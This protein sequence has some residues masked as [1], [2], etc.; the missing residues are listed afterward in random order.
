MLGGFGLH[1]KTI[2]L[3]DAGGGLVENSLQY[4][5]I[6]GGRLGNSLDMVQSLSDGL[7]LRTGIVNCFDQVTDCR[8]MVGC[9]TGDRVKSLGVDH[10][11][12]PASN[13]L[14]K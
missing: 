14:D 12:S 9:V 1:A 5:G 2:D 10:V 3:D 4:L 13:L 6:G 7:L 8:L 11:L